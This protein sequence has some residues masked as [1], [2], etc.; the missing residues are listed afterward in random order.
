MNETNRHNG[1]G[2]LALPERDRLYREWILPHLEL[3]DEHKAF[4][5]EHLRIPDTKGFFTHP[6]SVQISLEERAPTVHLKQLSC[7]IMRSDCM[8]LAGPREGALIL[9][10]RDPKGRFVAFQLLANSQIEKVKNDE[11]PGPIRWW[12]A[13]GAIR[14]LLPNGEIPVLAERGADSDC[15]ILARGLAAATSIARGWNKH[16]IS[17]TEDEFPL[18]ALEEYLQEFHTKSVL[19]LQ[20]RETT[21]KQGLAAWNLAQRLRS[22][23]W[24]VRMLVPV[25]GNGDMPESFDECSALSLECWFEGLPRQIRTTILGKAEAGTLNEKLSRLNEI[26]H[27]TATSKIRAAYDDII[28]AGDSTSITG[29]ARAAGVSRKVVKRWLNEQGIDNTAVLRHEME[30]GWQPEH[31][32]PK[33]PPISVEISEKDAEPEELSLFEFAQE[34]S[35]AEEAKTGVSPNPENVP[36]PID[37]TPDVTPKDDSTVNVL[38]KQTDIDEQPQSDGRDDP[39]ELVVEA[40]ESVVEDESPLTQSIP[41]PKPEPGRTAPKPEPEPEPAIPDDARTKAYVIITVAILFLVAAAGVIRFGCRHVADSKDLPIAP[42]K[43]LILKL[44]EEKMPIRYI[45]ERE[46]SQTRD[47]DSEP[48]PKKV[49]SQP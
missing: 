14:P 41:M 15:V 23:G 16:A 35:R 47:A 43:D 33:L 2:V 29:L 19:L 24:D 26:R 46:P 34:E 39:L 27:I 25:L 12:Q 28:A 48:A 17:T 42:N 49:D 3:S 44:P 9:P 36:V 22:N 30:L 18:Q 1:S 10:V 6:G 40:K 37:T 21:K 7:V 5:Q 11:T 38:T 45:L 4:V 31:E 32:I 20:P 13:T 8:S